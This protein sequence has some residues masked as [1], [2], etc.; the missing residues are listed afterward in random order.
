[1]KLTQSRV[2]AL[3]LVVLALVAGGAASGL[4]QAEAMPCCS[5]CWP[6][7]VNC[8]NGCG[9]NPTCEDNCEWRWFRCETY[10]SQSC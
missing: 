6:A 9:G 4:D 1:M 8:F 7:F 2:L 10:C 5:S 3:S